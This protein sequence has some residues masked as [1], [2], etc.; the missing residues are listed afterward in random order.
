MKVHGK[1]S[2]WLG[3]LTQSGGWEVTRGK[4]AGKWREEPKQREVI[5][6]SEGIMKRREKSGFGVDRETVQ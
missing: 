2:G 3:S 6:G 5:G 4:S 1:L